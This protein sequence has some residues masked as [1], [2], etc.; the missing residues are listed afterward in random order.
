M[1]K[2][3]KPFVESETLTDDHLNPRQ[4]SVLRGVC[5][6]FISTGIPVGSRTISRGGCLACS[7]ATIRNEMADLESMGYLFSPHTSAGRVPTEKGYRF[8][9]NFLLEFERLSQ[10]EESL[11]GVLA[12]K[13]EDQASENEKILRGAIR[14]ACDITRLGGIVLTPQQ[15]ERKLRSIQ[16]IRLLDDRVMM[17]A[18]DDTGHITDELLSVPPDTTD[19]DLIFLNNFLNQEMCGRYALELERDILKKSQNI[20]TKYNRL[21]S[22]LVG[23]VM[24]A[25]RNPND[26]SVFLEGFVHFFEQSEFRD[27][28]K[29]KKMISLLDQKEALLN[30]LAKSLENGEEIMVNIG[31]DSGL[32]ISDLSIVTARYLGPNNSMGRIGLIGPLRMNYGRVVATLANISRAL[33]GLFVG[34]AGRKT[35]K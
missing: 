17:V 26:D 14:L 29:M 16:L 1:E 22:S 30:I 32:A 15:S 28:E 35:E 12:K 34:E 27:N 11:V 3:Y 21:L 9:V 13:F 6:A 19:D 4:K 2:Q 8:Y 20:L 7:P 5:D 18:V 24:A 31:S 10:L 23:R 33:S 25:I